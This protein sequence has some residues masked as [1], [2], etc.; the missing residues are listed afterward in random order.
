MLGGGGIISL[1][2]T[3][4]KRTGEETVGQ[5]LRRLRVEQGLSQRELAAP[6]V[7]YAY[8]SRI[9][10]GARRPS[11]KALRKLAAKLGVS[12]DYLETGSHLSSAEKR[13]LRLTELELRLRL[14]DDAAPA[15]DLQSL[16]EEAVTVGDT[17]AAARTRIMV[18]L[19]AARRGD[20]Q[21]AIEFLEEAVRSGHA[22]AA[23]RPDVHATL[24]RAYADAGQ[25]RKAAELF[26]TGLDETT[27][28]A[29]SDYTAQV[30][31]ATYLSF[32]LTDLG[33]LE[34]ARNVVQEALQRGEHVTDPYTRVR[35]YW[36]LGRIAHEQA[37]PR[38]A[39]DHLRKALALL[40]LTED[41]LHLARAHLSAAGS[42]IL[43]GELDA[44]ER[45]LEVAEPLIG[46]RPEPGDLAVLRRMQAD[47]AAAH[48]D[49]ELAVTR[50]REAAD[51]AGADY[52]NQRGL[53][54]AAVAAGLALLED[55]AA[56]PTYAEAVELLEEH[57][58]RRERSE[59]LRAYGHHLRSVGRTGE[60]FDV[61]DRAARVAATLAPDAPVT[62]DG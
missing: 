34:Q 49:G 38:A 39:L 45:H 23:S 22:D 47:L 59:V 44:A 51:A 25:P 52:P 58:T 26:R 9:E 4:D 53:A 5:R 16:L 35:L 36:S 61:L 57:G 48:G 20:N 56:G 31:Y 7:S 46:G 54:L 13:D 10:A 29:P 27:R 19:A 18:G 6:G 62:V 17:L 42:A 32:A 28:G 33:E 21:E 30:R 40:E 43:T 60:A 15:H 2:L 11:V 55:D 3:A 50:G 1:P 41:T 12:P 24:G 14:D 8:I 37:R